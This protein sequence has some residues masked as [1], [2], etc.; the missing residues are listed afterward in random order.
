MSEYDGDNLKKEQRRVWRGI[1]WA[2][3]SCIAVMSGAQVF[4]PRWI[5]LPDDDLLSLLEVWA[6]ASLFVLGWVLF[7]I[8]VV[9]HRRRH[10]LDDIRGSAYSAPSSKLAV[11]VAFL[12]NTLEQSFVTLFSL[13]ALILL[14]RTKAIPLVVASVLLFCIGR[15]AFL[16]GYP[17]GAGSR[18]FGMAL[19]ALPSLVAFVL[20]VYAAAARVWR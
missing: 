11:P 17:K 16:A 18:S 9:S 15:A 20:A 6:S 3:V 7:G 4:V 19:T 1:L 8:G 10:S 13:L 12:Q 2:L 5:L 14:L